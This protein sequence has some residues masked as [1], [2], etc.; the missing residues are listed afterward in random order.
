MLLV[1][2]LGSVAPLLAWVFGLGSFAAWFW[3]TTVPGFTL[4]L[5]TGVVL[6]RAHRYPSLAVAI[7][8]GLLG[9]LVATVLYDLARVPFLAV[10][11]RLFA[12]VNSYGIL[13]TA[14][15]TSSPLTDLLGWTYNFMNGVAFGV[16]YAMFGLGRR[17]IWAIPFA[18]ALETMTIVT[19]Y[20]DVYGLRGKVDVIAIAYGAHVFYGIA[21]GLVVQRAARWKDRGDSPVPP[22]WV[23]AGLA[24]VLVAL[25]QPWTGQLAPGPAT[26]VSGGKFSPEW[27]RIPVNGCVLVE[28][29]DPRAYAP[30]APA[31]AAPLPA[32]GRQQYCFPR[33]GVVRVQLD[34]VP[35][36]GG[37]VLVDPSMK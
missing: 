20:A 30:S 25:N 22:W 37:W 24:V 5:V 11:Y 31:G 19:P 34:R 35:Y 1:A 23:A 29:R 32:G 15:S 7:T 16:A 21:L 10:G 3:F 18:M 27:A 13:M 36:S 33:A 6:R 8:A 14:A 17:R 26:L 9:G 2:G 4:I 12:P 28:N